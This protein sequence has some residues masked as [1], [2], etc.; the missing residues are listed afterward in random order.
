MRFVVGIVLPALLLSM[1]A[2]CGSAGNYAGSPAEQVGSP[3]QG[4]GAIAPVGP[5][6]L[7]YVLSSPA[8]T[9]RYVF[10]ANTTNN[11]V[12]KIDESNL[13]I[14]SIPVGLMP[15][16]VDVTPD[17]RTAAVFN[18][19]DYSVSLIDISTDTVTTL[20]V[21]TYDN[22]MVVSPS[23]NVAITYF[24]PSKSSNLLANPTRNFNDITIVDITGAT[25]ALVNVGYLPYAVVF[26]PDGSKALAV[27][28]SLIS[29]IDL[30]R[31]YAVTRYQLVDPTQQQ[32]VP[33]SLKITADGRFAL[34]V[35]QGSSDVVV[36]DLTNGSKTVLSLGPTVT[37]IGLTA[38]GSRAIA[39]NQGNG[40]LS[41]ITL[42]TFR[43]TTLYTGLDINSIAVSPDGTDA[44]LY[45][46]SPTTTTA[47]GET[48]YVLSFTDS[49]IQSYPVIKGVSSVIMAPFT[50]TTGVSSAIIV[51]NGPGGSSSDPVKQFFYNNYAVTMFNMATG[52]STPV[53][54]VSRPTLFA[55]SSDGA[56]GYAMM[57][58]SDAIAVFDLLTQIA[59]GVYVPSTPTFVGV[60]PGMHTA[61]LGETYPLGRLSFI[62]PDQGIAVRTITGF[63]LKTN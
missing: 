58:D 53:A 37:D 60:M 4:A 32:I 48:V 26:T 57:P 35:V 33:S 14:T 3:G 36:L 16:A 8:A 59:T 21:D 43:V 34:A 55:V 27:T 50:I 30:Y 46:N 61:Y 39:V 10:V 54:L 62:E 41:F 23:G 24:D 2:S 5:Q 11:T 15:T 13:S 7:S 1:V 42:S 29:V 45:T 17:N 18:A 19:G 52:V 31:G 22:T 38:D 47:A 49:S 51:H 63:E 12:A 40:S 25:S 6:P 28:T 56:Y 9:N 44:L 20:P